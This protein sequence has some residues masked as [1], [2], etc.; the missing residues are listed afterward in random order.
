MKF[1]LIFCLLSLLI[2][3]VAATASWAAPRMELSARVIQDFYWRNLSKERT[4]NQNDDVTT[5]VEDL[6]S[7]SYLRAKFFSEDKKVGAFAE[8]GMPSSINLRHAYGWARL[9]NFTFKAGQTDTWVDAGAPFNQQFSASQLRGFGHAIV[10]RRPQLSAAWTSGAWGGQVAFILPRAAADPVGLSTA[11]TDKYYQ[12]PLIALIGRYQSKHFSLTPSV[13]YVRV[14]YEGLAS[15]L[16]DSTGTYLLRLPMTL[17]WGGLSLVAQIHYGANFANEYVNYPDQA[18]PVLKGDGKM[19]D[20]MVLGGLISLK[21]KIGSLTLAGGFGLERFDNDAWKDD[22]GYKKDSFTRKAWYLDLGWK[23]HQNLTIY[24]EI[25]Y[26]DYGD[27]PA[28]GTDGG[29]EWRAGLQ[30][31]FVI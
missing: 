2:F 14:D 24:P 13:N 28:S 30:F 10:L 6:N 8:I 4:N 26:Y 16:D 25:V 27:D 22:L 12:L 9:G 18:R 20:T 19:E 17:S 11:G 31:R 23:P 7:K 3:G 29:S 1:R 5:L 21:Y 15:G